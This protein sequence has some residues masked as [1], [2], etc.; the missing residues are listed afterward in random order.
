[1]RLREKSSA[2]ACLILLGCSS[3]ALAA[4]TT[5]RSPAGIEGL[6]ASEQLL[7]PAVRGELSIDGRGSQ[8]VAAIAGFD[9][10][11]LRTNEALRFSLP[12]NEGEFRGRMDPHST[13]IIG[14]WIQPAG[15]VHNVRYASPVR[16]A[17]LKDKVWRGSIVPLDERRSLYLFIQRGEDG[18]LT[19]FFRN[20]EFGFGG[21]RAYRVEQE[22]TAIALVN[23]RNSDN[24]FEGSYDE[25][26]DRL[27]VKFPQFASAIEMTRRK[28][29]AVGF[30]P[31]SPSTAAYE[32][33]KPVATD[34]GWKTA[35]LQEAH[36]DSRVITALMD[37]IL[38]ADPRS[39][40]ISYI[41]S[42]LIARRG[43][44]VV[45]EYFYG[46][47]EQ[48]PHDTRS[49]SKTIAPMLV[50][51]A[52][53]RLG[54]L[55]PDTPVYSQ[56]TEYK[57]FAHPDPRKDALAVKHL[58]TMT[59]GYACDDND[60]SS[61]GNEDVMQG[62]KEQPDWYKYTLD[63]PMSAAPG[64]E[65]AVYCS[66]AINLLGGIV[67]NATGNWLP[68]LF[69]DQLARPLGI[70]MYHW[71][72]MPTGEGYAGGGLYLRARDQLKLGQ[73]YLSG[74]MWNGRRIVSRHWVELSTRRHSSFEPTFDVSHDYGYA[75][76]LHEIKS[77][78]RVYRD[79]A[80][81]GN[82]GQMVIVIPDLDLVVVF[83]GANYG[84]FKTWYRWGLELVPQ[85]IIPAVLK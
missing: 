1:V 69:F 72:L 83:N 39:S 47:D 84:D 14:H 33:H 54:G 45:E 64:A 58:M 56:F 51:I 9:V 68:E 50:G 44:L 77:G 18:A 85:Y 71:N 26:L 78:D 81:E 19:G 8:W 10:P 42:L 40:S 76:H 70:S 59:S 61:P 57:S 29:D 27:S 75:W 34:D 66:A 43:K 15:A 53:E 16:L 67:K 5:Q 22:K 38:K 6:W 25:K 7:G 23:L 30:F 60:P 82:G 20:P 73:L 11:V 2:A 13:A 65:R 63:L 12:G 48:R 46:F 3:A 36:L 74:G 80:A 62:Q 49:A 21:G 28:D 41:Q 35:S 17:R 37:K 4:E 79:Y 32:Y 52:G 31:R 24:R 55:R